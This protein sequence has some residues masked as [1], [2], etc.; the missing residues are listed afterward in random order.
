MLETEIATKSIEGPLNNELI[1][2]IY[3]I[4]EN[5]FLY[6]AKDKL[7]YEKRREKKYIFQLQHKLGL[8]KKSTQYRIYRYGHRIKL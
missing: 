5:D 1:Q 4:N 3:F 6:T 8:T 2:A 7:D